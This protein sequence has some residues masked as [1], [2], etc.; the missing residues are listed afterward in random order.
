MTGWTA[1]IPQLHNAHYMLPRVADHTSFLTSL[2][3]ISAFFPLNILKNCDLSVLFDLYVLSQLVRPAW[4]YFA[5][6]LW[7]WTN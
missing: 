5:I 3:T 1:L 4:V 2:I 7:T 6:N